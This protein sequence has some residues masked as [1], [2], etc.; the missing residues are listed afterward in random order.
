MRKLIICLFFVS[1]PFLAKGGEIEED[2]KYWSQWYPYAIGPV[3]VEQARLAIINWSGRQNLEISLSEVRNWNEPEVG[4]MPAYGLKPTGSILPPEIRTWYAFD[5][6]DPNPDHKYTGT[7]WVDSWT[8]EVKGLHKNYGHYTPEGAIGDMLLPQQSENIARQIV[9]SYF[10]NIPVSSMEAEF[11]PKLKN[12]TWEEFSHIVCITFY[13][14]FTNP[15]GEKVSV[16]VQSA[17]VWLDSRSGE[18]AEIFA[19]YEPLEV[20]PFHSLSY[21]E[22]ARAA[23]SYLYGLGAEE[24]IIRGVG[25]YD[26]YRNISHQDVYIEE[27]MTVWRL[28]REE[29]YGQQRLW[30]WIDFNIKS[31]DFPNLE[32]S[33]TGGVDGH[34]GE[35][36]YACYAPTICGGI[37][38]PK[39][40]K[41]EDS[42]NLYFNGMKRKPKIQPLI[43]EGKVYIGIEDLK[44]IGFNI[45]KKGKG[46]LLSFKDK[47]VMIDGKDILKE[48]KVLYLNGEALRRGKGIVVHYN[49]GKK[50]FH[51]L[52]LNDK[53]Y[54]KG[55]EARKKLKISKG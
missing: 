2:L 21:E 49:K 50:A 43:K 47:K 12:G 28:S 3:S 4:R 34:T 29:P 44:A 14:R 39:R 13:T 6:E 30:T 18:L 7:V 48:G 17:K 16:D 5:V 10:P 15:Q 45:A 36:I 20:S 8:G 55:L 54:E 40:E 33:W 11:Y 1:I 31:P 25:P 9:N 52:V 27:D 35:V 22:L 37:I 41:S 19:C 26:A 38:P 46:Y 23:A 24:V 32:Q 42:F 53:A 51:I